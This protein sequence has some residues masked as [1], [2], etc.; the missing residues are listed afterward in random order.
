MPLPGFRVTW[1]SVDEHIKDDLDLQSAAQEEEVAD[2]AQN[3]LQHIPASFH[4]VGD[5]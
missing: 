4:L 5:T 2:S 3:F 1:T